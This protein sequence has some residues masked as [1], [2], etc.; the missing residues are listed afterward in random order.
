MAIS[1]WKIIFRDLTVN[2]YCI[3]NIIIYYWYNYCC[4]YAA[5]VWFNKP[6][7][8]TIRF[9]KDLKV[10]TRKIHHCAKRPPLPA[11]GCKKP[12]YLLYKL[13]FGVGTVWSVKICAGTLL[14]SCHASQSS[15]ITGLKFEE[16]FEA[17]SKFDWNKFFA[18]LWPHIY[19]IVAAIAVCLFCIKYKSMVLTV[20]F[21]SVLSNL[22][23]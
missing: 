16:N 12:H 3:P 17:D 20:W 5:D 9:V 8:T 7:S 23:A 18:L 4:R 22:F 1:I 21:N 10:D 6:L 13:C 15:R 11:D 2:L 19:Y 14:V